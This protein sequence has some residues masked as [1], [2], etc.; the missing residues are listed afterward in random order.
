LTKSLCT[1]MVQL[2]ENC[3]NRHCDAA[4]LLGKTVT[5]CDVGT[6]LR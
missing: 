6:A 1:R 4:F 5:L 2:S 3:P